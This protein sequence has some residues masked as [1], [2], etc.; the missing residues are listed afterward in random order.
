MKRIVSGKV[1]WTKYLMPKDAQALC[2]SL[3]TG[4]PAERLGASEKG[5][6]RELKKAKVRATS[7]CPRVI[8]A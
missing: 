3:L 8:S 6:P 2:T 7:A 1:D 4:D 5:G